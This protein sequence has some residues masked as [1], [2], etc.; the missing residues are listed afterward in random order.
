MNRFAKKAVSVGLS[1]VLAAGFA[2][3]V[4]G[5]VYADSEKPK[6]F[7]NNLEVLEEY[8]RL[9][10]LEVGD[11]MDEFMQGLTEEQ[12]LFIETISQLMDEDIPV[13]DISW[14]ISDGGVLTISG[15]GAMQNYTVSA[16][17]PW[18]AERETIVKV[19]IEKGVTRIGNFAFCD[20]MAM[21][22]LALPEGLEHIGW[23]AFRDCVKLRN[24]RLPAELQTLSGC[25]FQGCE[26][27]TD[28]TIPKNVKALEFAAFKNCKQLVTATLPAELEKLGVSAFSGCSQLRLMHLP[29]A[30]LEL[31]DGVFADCVSL[32]NLTIPAGITEL[33]GN[34][35]RG[36]TKLA[37]VTL[38]MEMTAIGDGAF[39]ECGRL[40]K[41]LLPK[42]LTAVGEEAFFN[43]T[44]LTVLDMP[45][46]VQSIGARAFAGCTK[47]EKLKLPETL[48]SVGESAFADSGLKSVSFAGD[49]PTFGENVFEN[50]KVSGVYLCSGKGWTEEL[51]KGL[52]ENADFTM[53]HVDG[54]EEEL[55]AK[56]PTCTEDGQLAGKK[57]A[58]CGGILEGQQGV[59]AL[60]HEPSADDPNV[61]ARCEEQLTVEEPAA[62]ETVSEEVQ[63]AA[64]VLDETE[65]VQET[66]TAELSA[67]TEAEAL[68]EETEAS[69]TEDDTAETADA[70]EEAAEEEP[71]E[72]VPAV[73][74]V[75][76]A[77]TTAGGT[78]TVILSLENNPGLVSLSLNLV[79]DES[80]MQ[81]VNVEDMDL[82]SGAGHKEQLKAP[83]RL[84][85]VNDILEEDI[86]DC[87]ELVKLTFAV[88]ETAP[89]GEI[90]LQILCDSQNGDVYN[91]DLE[92]VALKVE[93]GTVK[94][95]S[96]ISG[97]VNR[98]GK[99]DKAD[100]TLLVR[101]LAGAAEEDIDLM[102]A[103]VNGDG[104]VNNLDRAILTRYLAGWED[105]SRLGNK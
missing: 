61:C 51:L 55:P 68:S 9:K 40:S 70:P 35:L 22:E 96:S 66:D 78:V 56:E 54:K 91:C 105:Y 12:R 21:T 60:G 26:A 67:E 104:K 73:L 32:E 5:Y 80:L 87:G 94:V 45:Q 46:E 89:N 101:Y 85:W 64:E 99:V 42:S 74:R 62:E 93:E 13:G 52:G 11:A 15:T 10:A 1:F 17:A 24:L 50:A 81:L 18:Y 58:A 43:C 76:Q 34:L 49:A 83:Y 19:V 39:A 103:D 53:H 2:G 63:L 38:P 90:G 41:V 33:P 14:E 37:S 57:C 3:T 48:K 27:L 92:P 77:S 75:Q 71:E 44:G 28:V 97:D 98:D 4:S 86:T 72:T 16:P 69:V 25:A 20:M 47:L 23:A 36:C 88:A 100:K 95:L 29:K 82:L 102:A 7:Q 6:G 30:L 79:Y 8:S 59:H 31:G 65:E 84:N